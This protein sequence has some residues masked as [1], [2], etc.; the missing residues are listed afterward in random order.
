MVWNKK[1]DKNIISLNVDGI[2]CTHCESTIKV[3]LYKHTD[4]K[5]V[6]IKQMKSVQIELKDDSQLEFSDIEN[7]IE[8]V[9]YRVI[10]VKPEISS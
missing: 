5:R 8:S 3:A 2:R 7:I 6:T 10:H 1:K 9:G 4:I